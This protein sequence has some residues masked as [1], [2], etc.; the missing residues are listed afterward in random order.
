M[1]LLA[2]WTCEIDGDA[3]D[4]AELE[5]QRGDTDPAP[6][7]VIGDAVVSVMYAAGDFCDEEL[8]EVRKLLE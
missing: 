5:T 2:I 1:V 3:L 8:D 4:L 7:L 6:K